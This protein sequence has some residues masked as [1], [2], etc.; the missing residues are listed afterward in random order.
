[1]PGIVDLVGHAYFVAYLET[2]CNRKRLQLKPRV[3]ESGV[4]GQKGCPILGEIV[5]E[6]H[7][8]AKVKESSPGSRSSAVS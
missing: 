8:R 2:L 6:I 4:P 5:S 3:L 1:M 7:N